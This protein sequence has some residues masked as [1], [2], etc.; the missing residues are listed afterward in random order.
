MP[1][2]RKLLLIILPIVLLASLIEA[3]VLSRR[4]GGFDWRA[5]GV[6]VNVLRVGS[7][8]SAA[9]SVAQGLTDVAVFSRPTSTSPLF[10]ARSFTG[11]AY[12]DTY[13]SGLS[14]P[15]AATLYARAQANFNPAA[16]VATWHQLD[17]MLLATYW[18][19][20]LFT[21]PSLVTWTSVVGGVNGSLSVPGFTDEITGWNTVVAPTGS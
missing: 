14:L 15:F 1:T 6:S 17:K 8:L 21:P 16:V 11:P 4:A 9:Q 2:L 18:V 7:D 10:A 12:P 19:R 3:L 13:P 20:P 5:A